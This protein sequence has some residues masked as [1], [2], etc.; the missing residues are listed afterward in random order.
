MEKLECDCEG[1]F[2]ECDLHINLCIGLG[3]GGGQ[4]E[5]PNG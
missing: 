2:V 4:S 5:R 1:C 3:G